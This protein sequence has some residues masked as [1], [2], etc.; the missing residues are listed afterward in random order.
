MSHAE[1]VMKE[2]TEDLNTKRLVVSTEPQQIIVNKEKLRREWDRCLQGL[3][4]ESTHEIS[5]E[6]F[7]ENLGFKP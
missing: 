5:F 7:C 2:V 6:Q 1:A 3:M 4:R